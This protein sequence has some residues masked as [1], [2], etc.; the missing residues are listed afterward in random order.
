MGCQSEV[1]VGANLT[2]TVASHNQGT[3][4]LADADAVPAYRIYEDETGTAI[5][6]GNMAKLDDAGTLGFYS[7]QI[8]A[9]AANGFETGKSY[10]I[11]ITI[12]VATLT[13]AVTYGLRAMTPI[14]DEPLTGATHN[15]ATSAGRRLRS[16]ASMAIRTDTAQAGAANTI[17]L[18]AGASAT[19]QVYTGAVIVLIGGTGEGQSKTIVN[20]D[21]TSKVAT[22]HGVW[23]T[24]PANDSEFVILATQDVDHTSHGVAQAGAAGSITFE[25]GASAIDD[26]YKS[27]QVHIVSGTGEEQVRLITAYDGTSKIATVTPNWSTNPDATSAYH[28]EIVARVDAGLIEGEDATAAINAEV[29]DALNVDTYAEPAQEN[30]AATASLATKIG[31]NYKWKRNKH[32]SDADSEDHYNDA[33]DTVD[34]KRTLSFDGT[35]LVKGEIVSGP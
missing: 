29:V 1:E 8:E 28:T 30:P 32:T 14:W 22:I 12:V 6:T 35:T 24:N 13:Y 4:A 9:T 16:L 11:Y 20:Y 17:T 31:Y 23:F 21:G 10:S 18:D 26:F 7:E 34:Q 25:A 19:D 33:G 2:F 3:G 27:Q 15:I 5:L